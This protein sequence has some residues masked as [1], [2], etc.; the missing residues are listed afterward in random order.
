[1]ISMKK[2]ALGLLLILLASGCSGLPF[3]LGGIIPGMGGDNINKTEL[4][5][6]LIVIQSLNVIPTPPVN[7]EDQF[8]VSFE[9]K[10]QD[11]INEVRDIKYTLFD[12]GL[13]NPDETEGDKIEDTIPSLAPL[14]T[15]FKQWV[16]NAPNNALIGHLS[17][18]CPI[19]FKVNYNY[20]SASQINFDVISEDR[21]KELQRSGVQPSFT[22]SLTVGRGPLKI[23]FSFGAELPIR[24]NKTLPLF[25]SV[26]DKGTGIFGEIKNKTLSIAFPEGSTEVSCVK[27]ECGMG[28]LASDYC[29][30][31]YEA[32]K[33]PA[34]CDSNDDGIV[35]INDMVRL[36]QIYACLNI[37]KIPLIKRKTPQLRCTFN[38]PTAE[39]ERTFFISGYL[40]YNYEISEETNVDV[41]PTLT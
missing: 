10:N 28:K 33:F 16:F 34:I 7:A 38:V 2:I 12:W 25:I 8:S 36:T 19:R 20:I 13:C 37:D 35:D 41:K 30:N 15:E 5:P 3:N 18:K 39:V 24:S 23:S 6:D 31:Y 14:Q 11:E 22:P 9:L 4:S 29:K 32:P 26:E 21:L 40:D 27:F 1:M 17:T